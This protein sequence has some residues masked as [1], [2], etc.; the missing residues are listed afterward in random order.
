MEDIELSRLICGTNAFCGISH[1]TKSRDMYLA[2]YF[3]DVNKIAEIMSYL[4]KE[5]GV[6]ACISSPRDSILK[7]KEM[8]EEE[9]GE[10][11]HWICTPSDARETATGTEPNIK[12]QIE[13]CADHGVSVCMP[14]RSWTDYRI[15]NKDRVIFDIEKVTNCIRDHGMIPGLSTHYYETI[16]AVK[17][18]NY[19]VKLIVQPLNPTG[20]QSNIEV[21]RLISEINSTNTQIIVIKPMAAGRLEPEIGL[22]FAFKNIKSNDIV[23]CGFDCIQNADYDA[24][25]VEKILG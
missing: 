5:F 20:F 21:N 24:Q 1:F 22:N 9:L 17:K 11:Y 25:V 13:W 23:A 16:Q 2:D 10:K 12:Q 6:N 14:H 19:D 3:R 7:A 4:F 8:V 15:Q 18:H